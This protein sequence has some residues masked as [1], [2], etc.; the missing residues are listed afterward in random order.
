[1]PKRRPSDSSPELPF[2]PSDR[3]AMVRDLQRLLGQQQFNSIEEVNAFLHRE[4]MGKPLSRVQGTTTRERAED[5][6]MAAQE[7]RSIAKAKKR[8]AEALALDPD[9][10]MAHL[11]LA[12]LAEPVSETLAH[13]RDAMAAAERVFAAEADTH[14]PP[15]WYHPIG[16]PY[17]NARFLLADTLWSIGDRRAAIEEAQAML[18]MNP[19]DNQGMRYVLMEWLMRAGS[20]TEI[21]ALLAA[22][23]DEASAVWRFSAALHRFRTHGSD[24]T[25]NKLL[26]AAMA[27]N[28]HVVPMLLGRTE[29]P[30]EQPLTVGYGDESEAV[31]Y[32]LA[33]LPSWF[34]CGAI[35]W[36]EETASTPSRT[37]RAT[38]RKR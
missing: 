24:A 37:P 33:A 5:L 28:E 14:R 34:E 6:V 31:S 16:R 9:C 19:G 30:T 17:M 27:S 23:A 1:M 8:L 7:E 10:V 2:D 36:L 35:S 29:L 13:C 12:E 25:S 15:V 3:D 18:V 20:L 26:R 22:Y 11:A 4:V 32:V 21:D 38:K